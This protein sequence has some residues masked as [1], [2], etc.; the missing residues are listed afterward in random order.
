MLMVSLAVAIEPHPDALPNTHQPGEVDVPENVAFIVSDPRSLDGIVMDE[1][2]AVLEGAWQYSTHTPPYVGIGYLHDQKANKGQKSV[3]W[4]PDIPK[5]G[6]YEVRLSHCYNVRRSTNTPI[7]IRHAAGMAT[8]IINQQ[9]LP[10]HGRL[11]RSLGVFPFKAGKSGM[12]MVSNRGTDAGKVVIADAVQFLWSADQKP[13]LSRVEAPP[14]YI[15][16]A[17]DTSKWP[18]L[19]EQG[20][21]VA[22]DYV[23]NYGPTVVYVLG[24]EDPAL[25]SDSFHRKL[26]DQ[27]CQNRQLGSSDSLEDR[28]ST[29]GK[30]LVE[31]ALRGLGDAYLSMVEDRTP[32]MAELVFINPHEFKDPYLQTRGIHEYMHVYQRSFPDTPTWMMEGGAEFFASYLGEKHGWANLRND[33]TAYMENVHRMGE[34]TLGIQDMEDID[35]ASPEVKQYYRHLAYDA[36]AWAFAFMIGRSESQRVSAIPKTFYPLIAE[37]GWEAGLTEYAKVEDKQAF[38]QKFTEFLKRPLDEQLLV[39]ATLAD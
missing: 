11:F 22:R 30:D 8:V 3:T 32:P 18:S 39:L 7:T 12:V 27:Y 28:K 23:G 5:S 10:Q 2:D 29:A 1:T 16:N 19:I 38:Y 35:Q 37:K 34:S 20:I 24:H 6:Y 31:K 17:K 13:R 9:A 33:M 14:A 4:T 26:V 21:N 15:R 36:G 25:N